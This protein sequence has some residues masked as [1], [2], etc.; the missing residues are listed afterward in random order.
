MVVRSGS[1]LNSTL[2]GVCDRSVAVDQFAAILLLVP[3]ARKDC[4]SMRAFFARSTGRKIRR[5]CGK[6]REQRVVVDG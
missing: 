5:F 3:G 4:V 1:A 2:V 6:F